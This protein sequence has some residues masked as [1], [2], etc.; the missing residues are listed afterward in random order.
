MITK[1]LLHELLDYDQLTGVFRWKKRTSMSIKVGDIAGKTYKVG[2]RV[3]KIKRVLYLAHRL[4]WLYMKGE[5]PNEVIDH[6]N[7]VRD[8]NRLSNLRSVSRSV[9]AQNQK[10]ATSANKSG[11][12]GVSEKSGKF[13]ARIGIN[14]KQIKIGCYN[15]PS[16]AHQAYLNKKRESHEGCTI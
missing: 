13:I 7:G 9:N 12:L 10:K 16:E 6:I 8:D 15:S 5:W 4:A 14:R 3:I 11:L 2:Y 1:D